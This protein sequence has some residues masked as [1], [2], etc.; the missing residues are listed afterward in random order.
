LIDGQR[1]QDAGDDDE[2]FGGKVF[3]ADPAD[4]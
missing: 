4:V 3:H 2:E 1:R